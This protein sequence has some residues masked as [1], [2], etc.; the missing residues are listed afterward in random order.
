[1]KSQGKMANLSLEGKSIRDWQFIN[2]SSSDAYRIYYKPNDTPGNGFRFATIEWVSVPGGNDLWSD[3]TEIQFLFNGVA[4][5]DGI[6]H[7]YLGDNGDEDLGY[8]YYPEIQDYI[9]ILQQ[10]RRLEKLYCSDCS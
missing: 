7:L 9:E 4:Y 1:M 2:I 3:D 8:V 10:I 5:F 6:R